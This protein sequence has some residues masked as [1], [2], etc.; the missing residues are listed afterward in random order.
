M[1]RRERMTRGIQAR[2]SRAPPGAA[3]LCGLSEVLRHGEKVFEVRQADGG[4]DSGELVC[5]W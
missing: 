4:S 5:R 3:C 2:K 1:S